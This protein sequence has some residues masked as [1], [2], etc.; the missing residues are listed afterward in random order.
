MQGSSKISHLCIS[1]GAA[2]QGVCPSRGG[3]LHLFWIALQRALSATKEGETS[4][5]C[6]AGVQRG[7]EIMSCWCFRWLPQSAPC[8]KRTVPGTTALQQWVSHQAYAWQ[9]R[10]NTVLTAQREHSHHLHTQ[11]SEPKHTPSQYSGL[12][13]VITVG[14]INHPR[15]KRSVL[16][17]AILPL[18]LPEGIKGGL[19]II[20][21][22]GTIT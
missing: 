16:F 19:S 4:H 22:S 15:H 8:T 21:L 20:S 3:R 1:R 12:Y 5:R 2:E 17:V 6:W 9:H 11:R 10:K 14:F 7:E 13:F 18:N